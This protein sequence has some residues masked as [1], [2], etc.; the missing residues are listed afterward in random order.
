[1]KTP[2][3]YAE[4]VEKYMDLSRDHDSEV[5]RL[6]ASR[7]QVYATLAIAAALI[8]KDTSSD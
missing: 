1:M 4:Q 3:E 5:A 6:F 2:E 8:Q 7:A